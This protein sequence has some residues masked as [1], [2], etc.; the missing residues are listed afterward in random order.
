MLE[1][2]MLNENGFLFD[3]RTGKTYSLSGTATFLIRAVKGGISLEALPERLTSAFD[4]DI[5][6]AA[7]DVEQ[8]LLRL[9]DLRLL[10]ERR[11]RS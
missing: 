4:L 7:R 5:R 8:F 3:S 6:T 1:N 11:G 10:D 9:R 2:A